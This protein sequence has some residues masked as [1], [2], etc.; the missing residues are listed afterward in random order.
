MSEADALLA[1]LVAG[2]NG[3]LQNHQLTD[4]G[5]GR[6]YRQRRR[7][8]GVLLPVHRGVLRHA[9]V[10]PSWLGRVHAALLAAGSD[11]V[12]SHRT[13]ARL[14]GFAGVPGWRPELTT[15]ATDQPKHS[16]MTVHRT[17]LLTPQDR[18][19]VQGVASTT[20]AR[21]LL[22]LGAV[23]PYQKVAYATEDA[24]IR[25]IASHEHLFSVLDRVGGRGRRGTAT[26]RAILRAGLPDEK[27]QSMLE[28]RLHQ[29]IKELRL[30]VPELQ[31]ELVC[32]DGRVVRLDFAWP[33]LMITTE[34][35]GLRWHGTSAKFRQ[36]LA[37][38]RS[39]QASG[40]AHHRYGWGDLIDDRLATALELCRLLQG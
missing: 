18:C 25:K 22:D 15:W 30:P 33:A 27:V 7:D 13:A 23:L 26:L 35:D 9:A 31:F 28:H 39:I 6:G 17:T 40:W 3:V 37:R 38:S 20:P 29:L 24:V 10:P 2:Q 11:A 12:A 21:T 8:E 5:L 14:H 36:D 16:G 32:A 34:A 4:L 1:R 19:V